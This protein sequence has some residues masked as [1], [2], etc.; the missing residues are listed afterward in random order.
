MENNNKQKRGKNPPR[1]KKKKRKRGREKKEKG[2]VCRHRLM[3]NSKA[4]AASSRRSRDGC[5]PPERER[6]GSRGHGE[7]RLREMMLITL[8]EQSPFQVGFYKLLTS[9]EVFPSGWLCKLVWKRSLLQP[10][11]SK[12]CK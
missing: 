1:F 12:P 9:R 5:V 8:P 7:R 6:E 11:S 3:L 2:W 10:G 4:L